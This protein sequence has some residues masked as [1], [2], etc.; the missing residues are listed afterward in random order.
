MDKFTI[1]NVLWILVGSIATI[2]V[3]K[4]FELFQTSKANKFELKKIYF[5]RKI[6]AA[7]EAIE[8]LQKEIDGVEGFIR[9]YEKIPQSDILLL[10]R[11]IEEIKSLTDDFKDKE[12][13]AKELTDAMFMYFDFD[14]YQRGSALNSKKLLHLSL[15]IYDVDSDME[16]TAR[17]YEE[18][19]DNKFKEFV[20]E[21]LKKRY[22]NYFPKLEELVVLGKKAIEEAKQ[23]QKKIIS[24]MKKY[25]F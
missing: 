15:E 2:I 12:K 21:D 6:S 22:P 4:L 5:E 10:P 16:I 13:K 1:E 19:K 14:E 9:V 3:T 7:E 25:D 24:E 20:F 18:A 11:L 17:I 8:Y 23:Q